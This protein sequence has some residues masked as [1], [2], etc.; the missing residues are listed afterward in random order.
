M[1]DMQTTANHRQVPKTKKRTRMVFEQSPL[2]E[3]ELRV[4]AASD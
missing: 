3:R 2:E 4:M 1:Q